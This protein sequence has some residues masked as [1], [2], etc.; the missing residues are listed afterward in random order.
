MER[1]FGTVRY[2]N[3]ERGYGFI[4]PDVNGRDI[5][6]SLSNIR[7]SMTPPRDALVSFI[8]MIDD[9]RRGKDWARA[10]DILP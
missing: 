9:T 4:R 2:W 6:V 5:H 3:V 7:N 1:E 8:R 10:V